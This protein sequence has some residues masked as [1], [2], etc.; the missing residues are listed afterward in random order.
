MQDLPRARTRVLVTA[1]E[2]VVEPLHLTGVEMQFRR[3]QVQLLFGS[4]TAVTGRRTACPAAHDG[5]S[6]VCDFSHA[7]TTEHGLTL[8]RRVYPSV[9]WL[10]KNTSG[11]H[12][13]RSRDIVSPACSLR[14]SPIS[15]VYA[16]VSQEF[17]SAELPFSASGQRRI[18]ILYNDIMTCFILYH[19]IQH[20]C[21]PHTYITIIMYTFRPITFTH[22]MYECI[23]IV[24]ALR[25]TPSEFKHRDAKTC[26]ACSY[27][28]Y[29]CY[30]QL[31]SAFTV[32]TSVG[33]KLIFVHGRR[34]YNNVTGLK[35]SVPVF[36]FFLFIR[37]GDL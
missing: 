20:E 13:R 36:S 27:V 2:I 25:A 4:K 30:K 9:N 3:R 35:M 23:R 15:P 33:S 26:T 5:D 31:C 10:R 6:I 12:R 29:T 19:R 34:V 24:R 32:Q 11:R 7:V 1:Q 17:R 21:R 16:A 18:A 22:I 14:P 37:R 8:R 28:Y